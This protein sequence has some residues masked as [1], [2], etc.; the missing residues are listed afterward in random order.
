MCAS[1]S[2]TPVSAQY[3]GT[4]RCIM[5]I[6]QYG[7]QKVTSRILAGTLLQFAHEFR[8]RLKIVGG[9]IMVWRLVL[10]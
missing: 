7:R 3:T 5:H 8:G 9:F 2:E 4:A 6:A 10:E 1:Y